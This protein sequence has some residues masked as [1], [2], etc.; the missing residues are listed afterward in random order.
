[1]SIAHNVMCKYIYSHVLR[2]LHAARGE[3]TG[4]SIGTI[5]QYM[6]ARKKEI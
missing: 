4:Q 2:L 5:V 1:M 3:L 6:T